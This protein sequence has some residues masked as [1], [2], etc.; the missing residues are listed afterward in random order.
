MSCHDIAD[1]LQ[2]IVLPNNK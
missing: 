1:K 2:N